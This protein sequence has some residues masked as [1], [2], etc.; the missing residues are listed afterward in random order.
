MVGCYRGGDS[1]VGVVTGYRAHLSYYSSVRLKSAPHIPGKQ[2][3][4]ACCPGSLTS[5]FLDSFDLDSKASYESTEIC[6][7]ALQLDPDL[8]RCFVMCFLFNSECHLVSL[9]LLE[10]LE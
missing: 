8:S 7:Y 4:P 10:K 5:S 1:P 3:Q 9:G 2:T 6:I